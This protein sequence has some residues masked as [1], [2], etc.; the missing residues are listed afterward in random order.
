MAPAMSVRVRMA[1]SPTGAP[2][3]R[4]GPTFLFNW[5]FARGRGGEC[6]LRIE[7]TDTSREVAE[8]VDQ[9]QRSLSWLG[10]DRDGPVTFQ[11]DAMGGC[12]ELGGH[13]RG[14]ARRTRTRARSAFACPTRASRRGTTRSA[15]ASSSRTSSFEDVV[16]V[17]SDGRPTYNFASPVEDMD[18]AITHVIRGDDHI[19]NTPKQI[20]ILLRRSRPAGLRA[21]GQHSRHRW[22]EALEAARRRVRG[23]VPSSGYLPEAMV[24]FSALIGWAP[25]TAT[26][27]MSRDEIVERFRRGGERQ[28]GY[29]RLREA[30]LD[31]RRLPSRAAATRL[32][33]PARPVGGASRG[34]TGRPSAS[35]TRPRSSRK[36]S[37]V[38]TSSLP[39]PGSCS[40]RSSPT[41]RFS[42]NGS[43]APRRRR[44]RRS[45]RGRPRRSRSRS[46]S[47]QDYLGEKPPRPTARSGHR[48]RLEG[49]AG[50]HESLELLGREQVL[51]RIAWS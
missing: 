12:R 37:G 32:L 30:R 4:L 7:N 15:V 43:S 8:A 26:T 21:R 46:S 33:R 18:D 35:T 49:L 19:S 34:S 5:L 45:S 42:T 14:R 2:P 27:I 22:A 48:D 24:N 17:R 6:L 41:P 10:I 3:H 20:Q 13:R 16:L 11:L 23:R 47:L 40:T 31:E 51:E 36:R 29:V 44:S 25:D 28:P 38:S 50:P 39:S 9:I 1:P